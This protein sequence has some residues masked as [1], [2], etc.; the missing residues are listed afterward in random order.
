MT[1]SRHKPFRR[2]G[3]ARARGMSLVETMIAMT[4]SLIVL[5]A[6]V[7]IYVNVARSNEELT[8]ANGLIENGRFSLQII[9]GDLV[10]AGFWDGYLPQFDDLTATDAPGDVAT[11][12]PD[13]CV[14]Y[15]NWDS[16]YR[17]NLVAIP[18]Q[19]SDTLWAGTAAWAPWQNALAPMPSRS[20]TRRHASRAI[21]AAT[22]LSPIECTFR[23]PLALPKSSPALPPVQPPAPS[24]STQGLTS[25]TNTRTR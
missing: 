25:T 19:A 17:T 6:L 11:A 21:P 7:S 24:P 9:E 10:H 1:Y 16:T 22:R 4:I 20:T 5:M 14:P 2:P 8:K 15:A 18:V 3:F 23:I 12:L 13:P